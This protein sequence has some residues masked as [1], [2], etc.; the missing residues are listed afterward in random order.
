MPTGVPACAVQQQAIYGGSTAQ[1]G[2]LVI[3][4]GNGKQSIDAV[5]V[6]IGGKAPT[7]I[8][9]TGS[10][11]SAID[12]AKPG[13]LLM[14]DPRPTGRHTPFAPSAIHQELLLMWKPVRLQGVGAASSVINANTHPAGK[15]EPW[16]RQ[17]NCL[18]GLALDGTPT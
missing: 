6:T 13:D 5:T 16:R 10:I 8:L 17:V 18:F 2:E 4:A 12:S 3:T 14:I 1:C 9:A 15:I 11:Q 7:H